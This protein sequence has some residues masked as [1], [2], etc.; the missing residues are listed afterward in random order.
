ML[1]VFIQAQAWDFDDGRLETELD[2]I[3]G[4]LGATGVTLVAGCGPQ[5]A[6]CARRGADLA[7]VRTRG[8]LMYTPDEAAYSATRCKPVLAEIAKGRNRLAAA[9]AAVRDRGLSLRVAVSALRLGRLAERYETCAF[10]NALDDISPTRLCPAN[11]DVRAMVAALVADVGRV[12][13]PD[14]VVLQDWD[15]GRMGEATAELSL[16]LSGIEIVDL[17]LAL[18]FCESCRQEAAG[19]E[20]DVNA[21]ARSARVMLLEAVERGAGRGRP[22]HKPLAED[23]VLRAYIQGRSAGL[24]RATAQLAGASDIPI[25]LHRTG[26]EIPDPLESARPSVAGVCWRYVGPEFPDGC[27]LEFRVDADTVCRPQ[28]LVSDV[29]AA[30][31]R[32]VT[33]ITFAELGR[34]SPPAGEAVKQAIRYARRSAS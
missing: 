18:C 23:D 11:P 27:E 30:T 4:T 29:A 2:Y 8:G 24:A 32:G 33:A 3:Q 1:H 16:P 6:L 31:A 15:L 34:L 25:I 10:K 9:A 12:F 7:I 28:A 5:V 13:S 26:R 17:L 20:L 21:A 14:A 22:F 19:Q